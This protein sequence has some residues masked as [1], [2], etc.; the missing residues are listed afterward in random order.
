MNFSASESGPAKYFEQ[1]FYVVKPDKVGHF[2]RFNTRVVENLK[3]RNV[4]ARR[5][6]FRLISGGNT[7]LFSVV[8]FFDSYKQ[9]QQPQSENRWEDDYNE[10]FGGG[11]WDEDFDNFRSSYESWS[12][13]RQTLQ[14]VP[15]MTTGMMK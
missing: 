12:V 4:Q 7:N 13:Q 9:E 8:N 14:L 15:E 6:L 1:T 2:R 10:L 3:K 11:S 5:G